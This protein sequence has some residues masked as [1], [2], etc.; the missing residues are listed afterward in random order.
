MTGKGTLMFMATECCSSF[1]ETTL[2]R[3]P[4]CSFTVARIVVGGIELLQAFIEEFSDGRQS[5]DTLSISIGIGR[6]EAR[7]VG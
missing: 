7:V 6:S 3:E 4:S 2:R 5:T 1:A